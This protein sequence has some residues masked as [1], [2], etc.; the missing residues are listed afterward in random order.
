[1]A[2]EWDISY[3]RCEGSNDTE[4][5]TDVSA[6]VREKAEGMAVDLLDAWTGGVFGPCPVTV[7]P[8]R[9]VIAPND[10]FAKPRSARW[11]PVLIGGR[12]YNMGC[13]SCGRSCACE[14]PSSIAVPGPVHRVIEVE[15]DGD[16]LPQDAYRVDGRFIIRQDGQAWPTY[17]DRSLPLGT[18][19]T[20]SITYSK[21]IAVPTG[22]QVAAGVLALEIM[23][24]LCDDNECRLPERVQ[25][26]TRQGVTMAMLD[27]FEGLEE[28][29][30]GLWL[31][32]SWVSSVTR[33]RRGGTVA[34]PDYNYRRKSTV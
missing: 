20:W 30:T 28:G 17:Q 16:T 5:L 9:D 4:F 11:E 6:E 27:G 12:W 33:P 14:E 32:D 23:R 21:G 25:T 29:R 2:C 7:R 34:S 18:E 31:V 26:I 13:S 19:G 3:D 1:M 15:I 10:T 24:A 8:C 22:G